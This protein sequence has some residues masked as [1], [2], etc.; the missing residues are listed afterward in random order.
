VVLV[1]QA[2]FQNLRRGH[3]GLAAEE[4]ITRRLPVVFDELALAI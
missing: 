3:H 4:S 2:F 1:G